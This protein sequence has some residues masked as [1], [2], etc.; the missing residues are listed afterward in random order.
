MRKP[1]IHLNGT[2]AQSLFD[3]Y[4]G[5]YKAVHAGRVALAQ[6]SPNGRDYYTQEATPGTGRDA[7]CEAMSEH[8]A[9]MDS[10]E[11]VERELA[12]LAV[13]VMDVMDAAP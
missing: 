9:R 8:I 12:A 13:H 2:A 3:A 1:T 11:A 5:A 7:T 10:L 6:C 4:R